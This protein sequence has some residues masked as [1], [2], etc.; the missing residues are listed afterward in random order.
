MRSVTL[1]TK[2][3]APQVQQSG[4]GTHQKGTSIVSQR[5]EQ[6]KQRFKS[7]LCITVFFLLFIVFVRCKVKLSRKTN[8]LASPTHFAFEKNIFPTNKRADVGQHYFTPNLGTCLFGQTK[9][10]RVGIIRSRDVLCAVGQ[11]LRRYG[12]IF[13]PNCSFLCALLTEN[14]TLLRR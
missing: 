2:I 4:R 3:E 12:R 14:K 6:R 1:W 13:F 5:E 8:S 11:R 7:L 10:S 9:T